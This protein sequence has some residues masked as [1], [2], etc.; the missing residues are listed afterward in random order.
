M[1]GL[2][3]T[4]LGELKEEGGL[5]HPI[6]E[7]IKNDDTLMLAIR[8]GYINIYYRGGNLLKITAK[9]DNSY[10]PHFDEKY[11]LSGG[12]DRI[13]KLNLPKKITERAHIEKWIS[14]VPCLK[15][16]MD[17]SFHKHPKV[18]REFQQLIQRE[19]NRSSIANETEYFITDI[20]FADS[21]IGSRID[22]L[23][24]CWP[25]KQRK[26]GSN[27]RAAL[28]EMKYGDGSLDGKA[29][30][31]EHLTDFDTLISTK[32]KY[33]SL[34]ETIESQFNQLD[35]LGLLSFNRCSNGIKVKLVANSK[36]DVIFILANHNPRSTK[37][38]SILDDPKAVAY[39]QTQHF[40]LRFFVSSFAGYGL[41]SDCM[42]TLT[43]VRKLLKS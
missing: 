17:F 7:Y 42:L 20:E 43:Q 22:M 34:I 25:A 21:D 24:I 29:G 2:S 4:F 14:S 36:P 41:H 18:E 16:I 38:S 40:D 30:L 10:E 27:C 9:K 8:N 28:I 6:L 5:L 11:D 13:Q 39:G 26:N 37:L 23:A 31:L 32:D 33:K 12:R 15:E 3:K 1:R 35:E 19:N